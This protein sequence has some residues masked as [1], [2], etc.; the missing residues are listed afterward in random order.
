MGELVQMLRERLE[1]EQQLQGELEQARREYQR[2]HPEAQDVVTYWI[3]PGAI[4][5]VGPRIVKK[6]QERISLQAIGGKR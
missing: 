2:E 3:R 6:R 5:Y 4:M 1:S